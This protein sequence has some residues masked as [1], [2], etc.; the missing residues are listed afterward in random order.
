MIEK[1]VIVA[2]YAG[3]FSA[4]LILWQTSVASRQHREVARFSPFFA[5]GMLICAVSAFVYYG[6][7]YSF[8]WYVIQFLLVGCYIWILA[9]LLYLIKR[10]RA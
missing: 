2:T 7:Q 4:I 10:G 3:V 8:W 9:V 1:I 6:L 5:W